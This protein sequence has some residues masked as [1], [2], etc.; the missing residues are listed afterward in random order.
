MNTDWLFLQRAPL[1]VPV[2]L[3]ERGERGRGVR[4]AAAGRRLAAR[5]ATST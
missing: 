4:A 1:A 2:V 5:A 3:A